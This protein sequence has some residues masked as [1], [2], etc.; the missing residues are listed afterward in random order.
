MAQQLLYSRSQPLPSLGGGETMKFYHISI[1]I[2]G[3]NKVTANQASGQVLTGLL[4][5]QLVG[6][7]IQRQSSGWVL[8]SENPLVY[9][10]TVVADVLTGQTDSQVSQ[11]LGA[12]L[13]QLYQAQNL[14]ASLLGAITQNVTDLWSWLQKNWE[15][16]A[17]IGAF[18]VGWFLA[19]P[20][21][22]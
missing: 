15:V 21:R 18:I 16:P 3:S 11:M 1:Q 14:D 9:D 5:Q 22:R 10:W 2:N 7:L 19:G 6:I 13:V 8:K 12:T 17:A 20:R 4:T